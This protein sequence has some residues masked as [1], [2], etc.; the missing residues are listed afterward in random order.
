MNQSLLASFLTLYSSK[1]YGTACYDYKTTF[2]KM[3]YDLSCLHS[4]FSHSKIRNNFEMCFFL[5]LTC[6]LFKLQVCRRSWLGLWNSPNPPEP[7]SRDEIKVKDFMMQKYDR[8]KWYIPPSQL[9]PV[10]AKTELS[11]ALAERKPLKH[12][13]GENA[14]AVVVHQ[15]VQQE[16]KFILS[17]FK[18]KSLIVLCWIHYFHLKF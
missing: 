14:P 18:I 3:N 10:A 11:N 5:C 6:I 8:K 9:P 7:E 4:L 12:L 17:L 1:F 16:Y 2:E 15:E 13:L